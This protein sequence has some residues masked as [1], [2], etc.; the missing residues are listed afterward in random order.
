MAFAFVY[1][2]WHH[3][4]SL[5][6]SVS[7][8]CALEKMVINMEYKTIKGRSSACLTVKRSKFIA[9]LSPAADEAGAQ[10]FIED[11]KS[12]HPDARHNVFAYVLY[13]GT[14]R[15]SDDGEPQGTAGLPVLEALSRRSL[16]NVAA[17]VTR[18][19]GGVLLGAPGLLRAY[20]GAVTQTLDAAE[21]IV[22][23]RCM[24]YEMSM[25][26]GMFARVQ[27]LAGEMNGHIENVI[28][29]EKVEM[30]VIIPDAAA[31]LF[32]TAV[33]SVSNGSVAPVLKGEAY[34]GNMQ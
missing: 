19:F 2:E 34:R 29:N 33:A 31:A 30:S 27:R 14:K 11:I 21:I 17:V 20:S 22:M 28:Y 7:N 1:K 16:V 26:Y 9:N 23:R 15:C 25:E 12:L 4:A 24:I 3:Q 13:S 32:L 8:F 10:R 18:Y 6:F 5:F